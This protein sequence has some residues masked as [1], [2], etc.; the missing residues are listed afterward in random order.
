MGNMAECNFDGKANKN[1]YSLEI[2]LQVEQIESMLMRLKRNNHKI[3]M[4]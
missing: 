2:D 3:R 4:N 1:I